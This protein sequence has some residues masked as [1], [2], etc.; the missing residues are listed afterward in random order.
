MVS[1]PDHS[2]SLDS[3]VDELQ[4]WADYPEWATRYAAALHAIARLVDPPGGQTLLSATLALCDLDH[5]IPWLR[6]ALT[7]TYPALRDLAAL[8]EATDQYTEGI[9]R[10]GYAQHRLLMALRRPGGASPHDRA[11]R[12]LAVVLAA[13]AQNP[14]APKK[15]VK[16]VARCIDVMATALGGLYD[17]RN[18]RG[19]ETDSPLLRL[20]AG[21]SDAQSLQNYVNRLRA[22][23]STDPNAHTQLE[24]R[25]RLDIDIALGKAVAAPCP[26]GP[27]GGGQVRR[28]ELPTDEGDPDPPLTRLLLDSVDPAID[29]EPEDESSPV[30]IAAEVAGTTGKQTSLQDLIDAARVAARPQKIVHHNNLLLDL[31][32]DVLT[33]QEARLLAPGITHAGIA[34]AQAG[35]DDRAIQLAIAALSLATGYETQRAAA[36]LAASRNKTRPYLSEDRAYVVSPTLPLS[37]AFSPTPKQQKLL[38]GTVSRIH[39][40]LPPPLTGFLKTLPWAQINWARVHALHANI[41]RAIGDVCADLQ[42]YAV[43]KG[44]IRR[45]CSAHLFA[46]SQ[47]LP[48]VMHLTR[49]TFGSSLAPVYYCCFEE[50]Y[51]QKIYRGAIWPFWDCQADEEL[52]QSAT[53]YVGSRGL[54]LEA[55]ARA[56]AHSIG[57]AFQRGIPDKP[58][59]NDLVVLH[60]T[61]MMHVSAM[62][63]AVVG[64]RPVD[65]LF[66]LTTHAFDLNH[67]AAIFADKEV[68]AAHRTRLVALGSRV[69]EQL[70]AYIQ[71]LVALG[72]NAAL[73]QAARKAMNAALTGRHPL[74]FALNN[75]GHPEELTIHDWKTRAPGPWQSIPTNWGRHF[76]A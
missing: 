52:T 70:R 32:V 1:Q 31:H 28:Y 21:C 35:N 26:P 64:H 55:H 10:K 41:G 45:T 72:A 18:L 2:A 13:R 47:D 49:D 50:S 19:I 71:N 17:S 8:Y 33:E 14:E 29:P 23:L 7:P 62:L 60:N 74:F 58:V 3:R 25:I 16:A 37:D 68:D 20:L 40:P 42:L 4:A 39:I 65:K 67:H 12:S 61:L 15:Q 36:L 51:L 5:H 43:T 57:A 53:R 9:P 54:V 56:I 30:I 59:L 38:T 6:P 48:A 76:L 46:T 69:S 27:S 22:A 75:E 66:S 44:R 24:R 34:A 73:P 11:L 63:M